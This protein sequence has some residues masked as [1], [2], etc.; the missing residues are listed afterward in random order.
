MVPQSHICL[1]KTARQGLKATGAWLRI[2][3][4]AAAFTLISHKG[5]SI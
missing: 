1:L 3:E 5:I 2:S 4:V